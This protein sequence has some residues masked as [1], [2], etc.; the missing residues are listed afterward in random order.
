MIQLR[1]GFRKGVLL[2][3]V[4][5]FH[6]A[7]VFAQGL[8]VS[9]AGPVSRSLGGATTAAPVDALG[10]L[11]WN[12]ASISGLKRSEVAF[13]SDLLF[14]DHEVSS[15]VFGVQGATDAEAGVYPIPNVGWVHH[16]PNSSVTFGLGINAVAGFKT[17]LP[18]DPSNPILAPPPL[19]LGRVSSEAAFVQVA[20]VVSLAV[21]DSVAVALGPTITLG[22]LAIRPFVFDTPNANGLYS[23]GRASRYHWGG[24]AQ[25][26]IFY[27]PNCDW[28]FGASVKSPTAMEEFEFYSEDATG[29][30][31]T[32]NAEANLPL[33]VSLGGAYTGME[34]WLFAL[35]LRYFDYE[36]TDGFGDTGVFAP[37]G[38]L[39]GLDW[40]S[41]FALAAGVQRQLTEKL[42]L[43]AGYTYNQNP[44]Q[45]NETFFN[46]A[47]PLIY[48]HMIS[49]GFGY[50]LN[51]CVAVN[52]A[53]SHMPTNSVSG[54]VILPGL[55]TLPNSSVTTELDTHTF[56]F[57]VTARY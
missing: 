18:S 17:N 7:P 32:L 49:A 21:T 31:R 57:G 4:F 13:S 19:G 50:E 55:G 26:G 23:S 53:Y 16:R 14:T 45:D 2:L 34:D 36:N 38:K 20:P 22:Q 28:N 51:P 37:T 30:P 54:P 5:V 12:P 47:S 48:E 3:L 56:S 43:R 9:T 52:F 27:V 42:A 1:M 24:G 35:D 39:I 33:I 6:T 46:I 8:Y 29:A 10:A 41:V 40:S 44:I 11:Y 15:S 25:V